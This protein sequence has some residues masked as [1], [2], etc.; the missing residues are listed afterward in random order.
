MQHKRLATG[1]LAAFAA[2]AK[3]DDASDVTQL[4]GATFDEFVKGNGLVLAECK[5]K[6]N[7]TVC[8]LAVG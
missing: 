6:P 1:L 3:A 5:T 2:I 7:F 4:T 8:R